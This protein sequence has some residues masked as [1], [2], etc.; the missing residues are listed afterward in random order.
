VEIEQVRGTREE[1]AAHLAGAL[2][3]LYAGDPAPA[4]LPGGRTEG[5]K[6]LH[7]FNTAA[8]ADR[9]NDVG[10]TAGASRLSPY[11]RH[12]CVSLP[13][14]KRDAFAKVGPDRA[15]KFVQELAWRQFWQLQWERWGD[16]ILFEDMEEPK[17]PLGRRPDL[18]DD[19]AEARTGLNCIDTSVRSLRETGYLF[20][21]SRMWFASYLVHHR[22]VAWQ[23]GARFFYRHLL[24]GDPASNALSWQWVAS[25][26]SHKPYIFN[27]GNVERYSRDPATGRTLCSDCPAAR[28]NRCPFDAPYEV[29]GRRLFGPGY[30]DDGGG[31]GGYGGDNRRPA[32]GPAGR[33]DRVAPRRPPFRR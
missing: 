25:T 29:L 6:R 9:R 23:T 10:P 28:S 32:G 14:A 21:H 26:F 27:R 7:V 19:I 5:L 13:E 31:R 11:I 16:R 18:P 8:Y 17:V 1:M 24:D 2:A 22:K 33:P 3:G 30:S 15:A 4:P 20:N 12:G